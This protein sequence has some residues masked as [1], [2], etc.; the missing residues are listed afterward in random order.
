MMLNNETTEQKVGTIIKSIKNS[1]DVFKKVSLTYEEILAKSIH[2][3]L[4][5]CWKTAR[6]TIYIPTTQITNI[7]LMIAR[8]GNTFS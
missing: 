5:V 6:R 3:R 8:Y 4:H 1:I 2:F 7:Y